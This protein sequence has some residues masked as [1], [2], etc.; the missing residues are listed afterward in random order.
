MDRL[1]RKE[2]KSD[3]FVE[4]VRSTL[5]FL[6]EHRR[7]AILIASVALAGVLVAVGVL[8]WR[9]HERIQ[10]QVALREAF[11]IYQAVVT[12]EAP[13]FFVR[14]NTEEEKNRAVEKAFQD[15]IAKYPGTAEATIAKYYLGVHYHY[16][17]QEDRAEKVLKEVVASGKQ[18]FASQAAYS[19]AE[20][21]AGQGRIE[22]AEKLLRQLIEHPTVLVPKEQATITLA[23]VI[24]KKD[25]QQARKLLE[26]LRERPGAVGRVALTTLGEISSAQQTP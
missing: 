26:P 23:K 10:R 4:K 1:T 3:K 19:L 13:P 14:F 9:R 8:A 21:Y 12:D 17:N 15:L 2:L 5:E 24:A 22:E 20:L 7:Q 25:P 11:R 16:T 18:P 6:R